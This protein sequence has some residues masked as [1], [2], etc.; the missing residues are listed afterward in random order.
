MLDAIGVSSIEELFEQIPSSHRLKRPLNLP[1]ALRSE[2]ELHRHM[3]DTLAK[4]QTCE[5]NLSF[6]GGGCWQHHVP[7][8]CDELVGRAEFLTPMWGVPESD[9]GRNQTWFE[10]CSLIGEL[11]GMDF[12]G[13]PV[14]SWGCAAGY[15]IRMAA[16]ITGRHEVLVPRSLDPERLAVIRTFCEPVEMPSHIDVTQVDFDRDTGR[17]DLGDLQRKLSRDVAAVYFDNPSYLGVIEADA[18]RVAALAH[19]HGAQVIVGVDPIS[20]GVLAPPGD[21][22]AD[23]VVGTMQPLGLHMSCGG[24]TGGFIASRDE[25]EYARQFPTINMT[26]CDTL[27]GGERGFGVT[28]WEQSSYASRE[29]GNDWTG[30]TV[31][32]GWSPTRPTSRLPA[33]PGCASWAT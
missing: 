12:V 8:I 16:R 30:L 28:L 27:V 22:G 10:F 32:S 6:L 18:A 31:A 24:A 20:L 3:R 13:L 21:Y 1:R 26:L 4:N 29:D 9:H 25:E 17:L 14:Y 7:A 23:L 33:R 19:E 5:S 2:A 15:A 11:V